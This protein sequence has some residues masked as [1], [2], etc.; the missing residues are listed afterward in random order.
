[1][2]PVQIEILTQL[3]KNRCGVV[4]TFDSGKILYKE[5]IAQPVIGVGHLNHCVIMQ[6]HISVLNRQNVEAAWM[7]PLTAAKIS[8]PKTGSV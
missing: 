2:G 8:L 5:T 4:P 6:R 1:M 3:I 7:H